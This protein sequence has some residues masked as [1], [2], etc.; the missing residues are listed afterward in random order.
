MAMLTPEF[1]DR[2]I[3]NTWRDA[4]RTF[5]DC[6]LHMAEELEGNKEM[7]A[8]D[9]LREMAKMFEQAEPEVCVQL[10]RKLN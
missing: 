4:E 2:L 1:I 7:S 9:A 10:K 3:E 6:L 5:H 8:S